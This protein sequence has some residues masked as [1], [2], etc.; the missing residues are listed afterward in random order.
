MFHDR[1]GGGRDGSRNVFAHN[2]T[3]AA[4]VMPTGKNA[5]NPINNDNVLFTEC[6][7]ITHDAS[8]SH[9]IDKQ[10][11]FNAKNA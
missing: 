10:R 7:K 11:V 2:E 6:V 1:H 8:N 5:K 9:V 4:A 3:S